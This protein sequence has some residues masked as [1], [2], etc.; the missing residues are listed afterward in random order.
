MVKKTHSPHDRFVKSFLSDIEVARDYFAEFLPD[1]LLRIIN[2][3][4]LFHSGTSL[5]SGVQKEIF[6]DVVFR[7]SVKGQ[8]EFLYFSLLFEHKSDKYEYVSIQF[9]NYLFGAYQQQL[10]EKN[11][12]LIPVIPF[13]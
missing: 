7:C 1:S 8:E 9:G 2:L 4:R 6:A 3:D 5:I 10:K 12:P 11:Y 13:L